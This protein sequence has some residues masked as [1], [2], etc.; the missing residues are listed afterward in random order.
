MPSKELTGKPGTDIAGVFK[1][2][3]CI[4]KEHDGHRGVLMNSF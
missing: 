2:G 1:K 4:H 3:N